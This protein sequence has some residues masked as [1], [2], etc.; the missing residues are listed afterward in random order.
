M[1]RLNSMIRELVANRFG[2][3]LKS[4]RLAAIDPATGEAYTQERVAEL[5]Q[6]SSS[7][8]AAWERGQIVSISPE[9]AHRLAKILKRPETEILDAIG[10]E[11]MEEGLTGDERDLLAAYRHLRFSPALQETALRVVLALPAPP[12]AQARP[13]RRRLRAMP[14]QPEDVS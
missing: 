2:K 10:Y 13:G 11:V 8:V 4:A 1:L 3:W 5:M 7:K 9:D 6:I 14:D 12:P